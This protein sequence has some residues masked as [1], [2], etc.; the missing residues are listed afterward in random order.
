MKKLLSFI[1]CN[2][3][4]GLYANNITI[5]NVR[6]IDKNTSAGLNNQANYTKIQF[7]VQWLNS[8]RTNIG[9]ANW[10]A[11]WIF[12]KYR[13]GNGEW[14]HAK[15]HNT[16]NLAPMGS[17]ITTGLQNPGFPYN[18][19]TN[20]GIGAFIYRNTNGSGTIT[21]N[22]V[23][24]RWNY[25][26]DAVRDN[27]VVDVQVYAIEMVY[28]PQGAF[29]AGDGSSTKYI[30]GQF[31][32][33]SI[34]EPVN[35]TSEAALTLGGK[36]NGNLSN[37]N[38][39]GM[40]P[41]DDFNDTVTKYLPATFPKGF[42]AFYSMKY[43]ITQQQY[44]DFLNTLN[45]TQQ[46]SRT[47][48]ALSAGTTTVEN[49]YVMSNTKYLYRRNSIRCDTIISATNPIVFYCDLNGND[50]GNEYNDG[51]FIACNYMSFMDV[52]AYLDWSGLRP[53]TEL[54]F[55][56]ACRGTKNAVID[57]YAWGTTVVI[58]AD[59]LIFSGQECE[60]TTTVG[61]NVNFNNYAGVDGPIKVGAFATSNTSREQSG[62]SFYGIME[63]SGNM[64]ERTVTVGNINGR[65]FTG[66]N[67]DGVLSKNG[68]ANET[69][70]PGFDATTGEVK[71]AAGAGFRGG[72][73]VYSSIN[74][75]VSARNVATRMNYYRHVG[76][77]GR[78]IR[79]AP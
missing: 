20:P 10:D 27:E 59:N 67:G 39:V 48:T 78:G 8:W 15:I 35:I 26:M 34:N 55:E 66:I 3:A 24:L 53:M 22:N 58:G 43:E 46:N 13:I 65:A 71:S 12:A 68:N 9:S 4:I 56:K 29:D 21:L 6:L 73:S 17:I 40:T 11:A 74:L 61:A 50:I 69:G 30:Q 54:E 79:T 37:N 25:G 32:N 7:D 1:L 60:T 64:Y 63:M 77:G 28:V 42:N 38:G 52:A 70:W 18:S 76:Y 49:K 5:T 16:D 72:V 57:E 23:R 33:G 51:Q 47:G 41:A 44:V 62:S 19:I 31:R 36:A 75:R 45:R 14:H 2:M